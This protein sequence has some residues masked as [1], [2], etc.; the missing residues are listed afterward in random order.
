MK[1]IGIRKEHN[2]EYKRVQS[3]AVIYLSDAS[4]QTSLPL[5]RSVKI[6]SVRTSPSTPLP[7]LPP[8]CVL[9]VGEKWSKVMLEGLCARKQVLKRNPIFNARSIVFLTPSPFFSYFRTLIRNFVKR[10]HP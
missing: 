10:G 2:K 6:A 3:V 8:L 1:K 9:L 7:C 5:V 4:H